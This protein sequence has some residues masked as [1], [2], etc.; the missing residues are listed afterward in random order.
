[1]AA[2]DPFQ[3]PRVRSRRGG[4]VKQPLSRDAIVAEALRQLTV[5]GPQGMSL[6]KVA[7]ALETGP[8][9]LY[10]Y[11]ED[12]EELRA[13][14]LDRALAKVD[15]RCAR[16]ADWRDRV[17][18]VL[19]SYSRVLCASPGLAQ[20]AFGTIAVGPN[21]LR[22]TEALLGSLAQGGI[23]PETRAW[24]VDLLILQVTAVAAEHAEGLEPAAP[25]GR[26]ARAVASVSERDYPQIHASRAHL[27]SGTG[28]QRLAWAIDVVLQGI[29]QVPRAPAG[30]PRRA[31]KG[32]RRAR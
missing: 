8:A 18:A 14:V 12:L 15:V 29:R 4:P 5:E 19:E 3:A 13:L 32:P 6:R 17:C 27:L 7:A 31:A 21:A 11:V 9:S 28:A 24:A 25:G 1:M 22:I 2:R 10:A 30:A 20:L 26:V 16:A 23:A